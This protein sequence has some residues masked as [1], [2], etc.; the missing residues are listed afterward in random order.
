MSNKIATTL[1]PLNIHEEIIDTYYV[2][3][4]NGTKAVLT[5]KPELTYFTAAAFWQQIKNNKRNASYI[6]NK[7]ARLKAS[8]DIQ[9][10][11]VIR[12]LI[13]WMYADATDYIGLSVEEIKQLPPDVR[14]CIGHIKVKKK[15]YFD[16]S[17]NSEVVEEYVEVKTQDKQKAAESLSKYLGLYEQD[18][19]QKGSQVN[20]MQV[21]QDTN[22][23]ALNAIEMAMKSNKPK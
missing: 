4:F 9:N 15:T 13:Q 20:I 10:E 3:G 21:L 11:N 22:P 16:K 6:E 2:N 1:E 19:R 23:E 14:R 17:T 18:N 12:E 7:R 8:A 5:L